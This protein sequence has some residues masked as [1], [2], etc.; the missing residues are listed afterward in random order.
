[1]SDNRVKFIFLFGI[2]FLITVLSAGKG[3]S[4]Q[5]GDSLPISN[6]Q[7][8]IPRFET[9]PCP[10]QIPDGIKAQCGHLFVRESRV[11][12]DGRI[13][14]L[15]IVIIK[16]TSANPAADPV[17]YTAGGPG[18]GSL[19]MARGAKNLAPFTQERDFIIFEQRGTQYAEPNLQ[20]P[21]VNEAK[22]M[23]W[24]RNLDAKASLRKEVRAARVCRD[25]LVGQ[26]VDLAAYNSASS[27]A[28]IE[29]LRRVLEIERLNLYGISY[30][31]RLMLN[32][33]REYP[34]NVRSVI[35]DSVLPTTVNWDETGIDG[36]VNSL[37]LIF[38]ACAREEKCAAR[39]PKLK[40]RFYSL[41]ESADKKPITVA[42]V[43]NGQSYPIKINGRAVVDFVYNLLESTRMLSQFPSTIEALGQG[44]YDSLKSYAENNLTST[45]FIWGMR[46]SVWCREEMPFQSRRKIE[47]QIKKYPGLK[48]FAIQ[49][50][51]PEICRV[52]D[53]PPAPA[54][55]NR[56]VKSDVPALIFA[57]QFDPDTPPAW[58]RLVGSWFP[59]SFF[60]EVKSSSHGAMNSRCT[61]A[62]IPAAFL[63]DPT[64]E[65]D[66]TCLSLIKPLDF[67]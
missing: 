56:P 63:K 36:V 12:S 29:D 2:A 37:E 28:D 30:S 55:E 46:Y 24:Q 40:E 51:F 26:G 64:S 18:A 53:V 32:Y 5:P 34:E 11:K 58:G 45:G 44:N 59:N 22:Q 50:A 52:W 48:G 49:E 16:S 61:F 1:M 14:K 66:S 4:Q 10:V 9:A 60:Y 33:V 43:K 17:L 41:V 19:G 27:A 20:C 62:E 54:V 15:P 65:P 21:E 39:Y 57:G 13:I 31:T 38:E 8:S 3:Q 42:A 6:K 7:K 47:I 25:R 67:K 23:S 35:L